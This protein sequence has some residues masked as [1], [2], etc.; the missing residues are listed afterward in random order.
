MEIKNIIARLKQTEYKYSE[1]QRIKEEL[2]RKPLTE[3]FEIVG[4][5]REESRKSDNSDLI[6]VINDII[7]DLN[8]K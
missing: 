2:K 1:A 3:Q 7:N 8:K 6:D 5:L 4:K